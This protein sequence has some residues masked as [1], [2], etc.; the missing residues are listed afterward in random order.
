M[1]SN[2][3]QDTLYSL[4][5]SDSRSNLAYNTLLHDYT[6]YHVV[7]LIEG[8]IFTLLLIVLSLYSWQQFKRAPKAETRNWT[9]EKKTYFCFGLVSNVVT[10]L[11]LL[12]LAANLSNVLNPQAGF[13]Q[14]I[15]DLSTPQAGTQ[16]AALYQAVRSR[17]VPLCPLFC[18]IE[19]AIAS[20]GRDQRQLSVA[21]C[22]WYLL[23]SPHAYGEN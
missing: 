8:G 10:V 9:F 20:R 21:S 18:K 12:I 16:K 13:A 23:F 4:V 6:Q 14:A 2:P 11:M 22:L 15:P 5:K 19:C 17:A 3:L 7:F 1:N